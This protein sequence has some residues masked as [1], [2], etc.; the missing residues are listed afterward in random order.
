MC[1]RRASRGLAGD[2]SEIEVPAGALAEVVTYLE[3]CAPPAGSPYGAS[4][5]APWRLERRDP[6]DVD[7][8]LALYREIGEEWLWHSRLALPRAA[9]ARMLAAA[10]V[11]IYALTRDSRD[12]GLAELN[13]AEPGAVEIAFFGVGASEIGS[14]AA[15]WLMAATLARAWAERSGRGPDRVWLHT[16]TFDHPNALPFYLRQGFRAYKRKVGIVADPRLT[17]VLAPGAGAHI[18]VIPPE[19]ASKAGGRDA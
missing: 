16:C 5:H 1:R 13:F 18:P 19:A 11:E 9:L 15:R 12:V 10:D 7:W 6:P 14:G 2:Y 4:G 17:G 8:Y 3:M